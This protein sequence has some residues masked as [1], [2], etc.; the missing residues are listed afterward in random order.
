MRRFKK[1]AAILVV[2][3]MMCMITLPVFA[4]TT[5]V[6]IDRF[7]YYRQSKVYGG[8]WQ[9]YKGITWTKYITYGSGGFYSVLTTSTTYP[10]ESLLWRYKVVRKHWA[11]FNANGYPI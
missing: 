10:A 5:Q 8:D 4:S 6:T 2:L 3:V 9:Y 7:Y 1:I 11:Y